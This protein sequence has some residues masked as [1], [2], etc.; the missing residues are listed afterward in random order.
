MKH[1]D[2]NE[3]GDNE[4]AP[5]IADS[6]RLADEIGVLNKKSINLENDEEEQEPRQDLEK[7][8]AICAE[9]DV[10]ADVEEE[11]NA[12]LMEDEEAKIALKLKNKAKLA[13]NINSHPL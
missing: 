9:N 1:R 12:D 5:M 3:I 7:E 8:E 6:I 4:V 13:G 11:E 10:P 2:N